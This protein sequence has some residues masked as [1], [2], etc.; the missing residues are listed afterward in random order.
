MDI[1]K[2]IYLSQFVKLEIDEIKLNS[3]LRR[4]LLKSLEK[5]IGFKE[6]KNETRKR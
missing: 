4:V 1:L 3:L 2:E 6:R 5:K